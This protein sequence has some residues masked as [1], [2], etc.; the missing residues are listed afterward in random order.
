LVGRLEGC[1]VDGGGV[2]AFV[3][4]GVFGLEP[5]LAALDV[6]QALGVALEAQG[7]DVRVFDV[8]FALDGLRRGVEAY[9]R[10]CLLKN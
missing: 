3:V 2:D 9:G 5:D 10:K 8:F 1:E 6:D 4:L 7:L